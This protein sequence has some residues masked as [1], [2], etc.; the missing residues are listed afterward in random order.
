MSFRRFINK[1]VFLYLAK[2]MRDVEFQLTREELISNGL[3]EI[4]EETYGRVNVL[5]NKGSDAKIKIGKYC[6]IATNVTFITGGI[7]PI[8]WVSLF[9]FRINW[10]LENAYSDGMPSTNGTILIGNDVWISTGVTILSGVTIGNG[11]AI[12]SNTLVTKDVPPYSVVGG[13]PAKILKYRFNSEQIEQL[14]RIQWWN[15]SR[16]KIK[17]AIPFLSD[18]NIEKFINKYTVL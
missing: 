10:Q 8:D 1:K 3:L 2:K 6:S 9:P 4:G 16:N 18:N 15:W 7:H 11:A 5:R 13:G 14:E 12:A 17:E